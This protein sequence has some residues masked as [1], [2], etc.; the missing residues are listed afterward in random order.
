MPPTFVESTEATSTRPPSS[1]PTSSRTHLDEQDT[2]KRRRRALYAEA[3]E[4]L[5]R[6]IELSYQR[7]RYLKQRKDI[8]QDRRKA[9]QDR[10]HDIELEK[11]DLLHNL[12]DLDFQEEKFC[13]AFTVRPE[14]ETLTDE[15]VKRGFEEYFELHRDNV[16]E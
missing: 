16:P 1:Q 14:E 5:L 3:Y 11:A 2:E 9:A 7:D 10:L 4:D 15:E 6:H 13:E 12:E 8:F